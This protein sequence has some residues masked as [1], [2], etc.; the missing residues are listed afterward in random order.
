MRHVPIA[1]YFGLADGTYQHR[2]RP[3]GGLNIGLTEQLTALVI[4]DGAHVHPML[5]FSYGRHGFSF[6]L[7]RGKVPGV[8]YSIV[9]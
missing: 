3:I 2:F 7:V 1:P 8:S 9:F 4:Y 5:N 6:L